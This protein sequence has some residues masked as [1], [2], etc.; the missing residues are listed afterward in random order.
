MVKGT[1]RAKNRSYPVKKAHFVHL[2]AIGTR[3]HTFLGEKVGRDAIEMKIISSPPAF[4][5]PLRN[6]VKH[7]LGKPIHNTYG[8]MYGVHAVRML[9]HQ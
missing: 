3:L 4:N 9:T 8:R 5:F 7:N 1:D 6:N 2:L